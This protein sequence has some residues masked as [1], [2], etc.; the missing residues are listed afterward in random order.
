MDVKI[1]WVS[2]YRL[3]TDYVTKRH[4]ENQSRSRILLWIY[5]INQVSMVIIGL[6]YESKLKKTKIT[7][8]KLN[9]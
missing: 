6:T 9:T 2:N 3:R 1:T 5:T 8:N 4:A 7:L